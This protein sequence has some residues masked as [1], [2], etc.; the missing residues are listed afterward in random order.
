ML[1]FC[2]CRTVGFLTLVCSSFSSA[3]DWKLEFVCEI[4]N[5]NWLGNESRLV[6][7]DKI[8]SFERF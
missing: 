3:S 8:F 5:L 6:H 1:S 7:V 4:F 2:I